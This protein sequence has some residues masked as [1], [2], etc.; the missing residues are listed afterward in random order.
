M[1]IATLSNLNHLIPLKRI[2]F[3]HPLFG[4]L[5][6][7]LLSVWSP[8][9]CGVLAGVHPHRRVRLPGLPQRGGERC[10]QHLPPEL[11]PP[12]GT[13]P[14]PSDPPFPL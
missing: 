13:P 1:T 12:P 10:A 11:D 5:R 2:R 4:Y 14:A 7:P 8:R 9:S 3:S 6:T